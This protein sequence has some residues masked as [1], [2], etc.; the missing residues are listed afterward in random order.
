MTL[1]V[2]N[3]RLSPQLLCKAFTSVNSPETH[4]HLALGEDGRLALGQVD[5]RGGDSHR[6][7]R[8]DG[9]SLGSCLCLAVCLDLRVRSDHHGLLL[10]VSEGQGSPAPGRWEVLL[11]M[12]SVPAAVC[13]SC[14]YR[15]IVRRLIPVSSLLEMNCYDRRV[16]RL[17]GAFE[18]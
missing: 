12:V 4:L 5:S 7:A 9:D 18:G 14:T 17:P 8:L 3:A 16:S 10:I 2:A 13:V 15:Q 6:G 1:N 11:C